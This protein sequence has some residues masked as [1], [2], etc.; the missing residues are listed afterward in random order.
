MNIDFKNTSIT[1]E[2]SDQ[3]A[4]EYYFR[5]F[6]YPRLIVISQQMKHFG[7][8][9]PSTQVKVSKALDFEGVPHCLH[10]CK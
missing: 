1:R 3:A 7:N 5:H 2:L 8:L 10:L 9:R 4:V 6:N